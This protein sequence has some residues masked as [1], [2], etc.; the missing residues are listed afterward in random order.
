KVVVYCKTGVNA[1]RLYWVLRYLGC[2]NVYILNGHMKAWR[3]ARKPV[4]KVASKAKPATFTPEVNNSI[5]VVK[6]YV[7][8][9]L[10]SPATVLIDVRKK[11]DFDKGTIGKSVNLPHKLFIDDET[12][13]LKPVDA[14]SAIF[15][16]AG[17]TP[18]KEII[19]Y[20]ESSA[21][22]GII[23]FVLETLLKYPNVKVYDGAYNEWQ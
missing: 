10:N 13:K 15:K 6:S 8:S 9:K 2:T 21:R 20:C 5:S 16:D 22:A 4:T 17:I 14:M 12:K 11:E 23:F 18:D 3:K 7:E 19:L 1:G